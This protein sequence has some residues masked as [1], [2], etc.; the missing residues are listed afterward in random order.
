M[1]KLENGVTKLLAQQHD[2]IVLIKTYKFMA[3]QTKDKHRK[4]HY[5]V[6]ARLCKVISELLSEL[7]KIKQEIQSK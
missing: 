3:K 7:I 4:N 2:A 5:L 1:S 6:Q